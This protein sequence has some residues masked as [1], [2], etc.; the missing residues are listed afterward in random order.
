MFEFLGLEDAARFYA[1]I[2]QLADIYR[3]KLP[4]N[5]LDHRYEDMVTDFDGRIQAVC[6]F[7]GA[8]WAEDMRNFSK[9]APSVDIRSPSATQVRKPL[10]DEAVAQW[11]RY[12]KELEPIMPILKPWVE[13]FGYPAE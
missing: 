2:M 12:A 11:R 5:I 9:N 10:Y 8:E 13:K 6:N 1:S 4:L 7:I 3:K